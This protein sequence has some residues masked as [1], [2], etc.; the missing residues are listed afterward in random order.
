MARVFSEFEYE[1]RTVEY[2]FRPPK[3]DRRHLLVIFSGGFVGGIDFAGQSTNLIESAILW[4]RDPHNSY[5]IQKGADPWYSHS[6]DALIGEHVSLLNIT[7]D[8][9]VLLG[10]SKGGTAALYHGLSGG[11]KNI[12]ASAPRIHPAK[13]NKQQRPL[14]VEELV[15]SNSFEAENAFDQVIPNLLMASPKEK[16]IYIFTS[17]ADNQYST[18]IEP[19]I[20][21]FE[22][23]ANFNLIC[24]DSASVNQHEDV[25]LYN[26]QPIM[27]IIGLLTDGFAPKLDRNENGLKSSGNLPRSVENTPFFETVVNDVDQLEVRP[28][29]LW[30]A[31]RSFIRGYDTSEYG[32][33]RRYLQ[34]RKGKKIHRAYLGGLKDRRNNRDYFD[35]ESISYAAGGYAPQGNKPIHLDDLDPGAYEARMQ[36]TTESTTLVSNE[37]NVRSTYSFHAIKDF[38]ISVESIG[39]SIKLTKMPIH[40]R[41]TVDGQYTLEQYWLK[42]G[43]IHLSGR[44]CLN[45]ID[46]SAWSDVE[47]RLLFLDESTRHSA[48]QV[49]LAK[50]NRELN[51]ISWR[52]NS[53][54]NYSTPRHRGITLPQLSTG[55]YR[56]VLIGSFKKFI[57]TVD[58]NLT[59][60]VGDNPNDV[61]LVK[62]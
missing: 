12:V 1:D 2:I 5:Y 52:D 7:K 33:A 9:V 53:K 40:L 39:S 58:T 23:Y 26:I 8:D 61:Q 51:P 13:G 11:Y 18:D 31:G 45:N 57:Q 4:I 19:N 36:V 14:I 35:H 49:S 17:L 6:A 50:Y 44:F 38:V 34:L 27:S 10:A 22:Q 43:K 59:L 15:G 21:L 56:I 37:F 3:R 24:T 20:P 55:N 60:V 62:H 25:T 29:G 46:I 32:S 28:D 48:S 54:S 30:I 16:N 41:T 47:Y 42:D